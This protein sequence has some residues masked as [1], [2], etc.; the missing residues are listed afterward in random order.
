MLFKFFVE[1]TN[2][3]YIFDYSIGIPAGDL[4][5]L[6]RAGDYEGAISAAK[7]AF[8]CH[9]ERRDNQDIG[10]LTGD[11]TTLDIEA[12]GMTVSDLWI[13]DEDNL[14]A[15][16]RARF[17]VELA[18]KWESISQVSEWLE[19]HRSIYDCFIPYLQID[20]GRSVW[21]LYEPTSVEEV[22]IAVIDGALS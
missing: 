4:M 2:A 17:S 11:A 5:P 12:E 21:S 6:L 7:D 16:L 10:A 9:L 8:W 19:H 15:S 20:D 14:V 13:D 3:E 1:W 22:R 18:V